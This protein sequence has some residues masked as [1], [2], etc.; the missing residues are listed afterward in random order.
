MADT[1]VVQ[2]YRDLIVT[3]SGEAGPAGV[4]E[5]LMAYA[6]R[7]DFVTEDL[8]YIGEATVGTPDDTAEW[9]VKRV[10]FAVDGDVTEEWAD[11]NAAFDK[12]WTGRASFTYS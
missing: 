5:S 2:E 3:A 6:K 9:R 12:A 1:I 8:L 7:V 11:G 4:S 10:A